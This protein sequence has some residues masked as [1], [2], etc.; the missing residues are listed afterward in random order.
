MPGTK[1]SG[2][3]VLRR[4]R[5]TNFAV[6]KGQDV[7][8]NAS[9][10]AKGST[11]RSIRTALALCALCVVS[12]VATL[13]QANAAIAAP[14][15][16]SLP[17]FVHATVGKPY[18]GSPIVAGGTP[19][20]TWSISQGYLPTLANGSF[21]ATT[22]VLSGTPT[23]VGT[24]AFTVTVSDS[25][26]PAMRISRRVSVDVRP[27]LPA[28]YWQLCSNN[29]GN[30]LPSHSSDVSALTSP[31]VAFVLVGNWWCPLLGG[32]Q[33]SQCGSWTPSVCPGYVGQSCL[34][35]GSDLL[36]ALDNLMARD[37]SD[38]GQ[39]GYDWGLANYYSVT[40]CGFLSSCNTTYVGAGVARRYYAPLGGA[41]YAGPIVPQWSSADQRWEVANVQGTLNSLAG[42][43]G[44]Q[45]QSD[46]NNTVFVLLYAPNLL[47][48]GNPSTNGETGSGRIGLYGNI[49][50]ANIYLED[51][52]HFCSGDDITTGNPATS[53][54]PRQFATFATSH[55]LDEAITDPGADP[56]GWVVLSNNSHMQTA[57]PCHARSADG[58]TAYGGYPYNNFTR[59]S[60]GTVV[61]AYVNPITAQCWP[62]VDSGIPPG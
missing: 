26:V 46:I 8:R 2:S 21:D 58:E 52:Q 19:P 61:S 39:G 40:N 5:P 4:I 16:L 13:V 50:F 60:R 32:N 54:S 28:Q 59:D 23:F 9:A 44:I 48:C 18:H 17:S 11:K 15:S 36:L 31:H 6:R 45:S 30:C 42:G 20:Y 41:L 62:A 12:L 37:Y 43:F 34:A 7:G 51:R 38:T 35:E 3:E 55:E 25:S 47:T 22:G 57:D 49:V 14:L 56:N 33:P 29:P 27:S 53:I 10:F 24:S 1:C